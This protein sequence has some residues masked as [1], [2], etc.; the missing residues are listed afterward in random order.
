MSQSAPPVALRKPHSQ[1]VEKILHD[2]WARMNVK[3]EHFVLSVVGREGAGK[4]HTA[5]KLGALLD[6]QFSPNQILFGADELLKLLR[7]EEYRPGGVYVLDEAGV[8]FGSRTWQEKAQVKANQALQ[9]IRSHNI[10]LVFTLPRLSELDSQT[11]GR[12]HAFYEI[13][14]KVEGKF[15]RGK[16]KWVYP[17]RTGKTGE[18]YQQYPRTEDGKITSVSFE[19][20]GDALVEPY[21][22]RK[23]EFQRK[24]YDEALGELE[25]EDDSGG[26]SAAEI[27]DSIEESDS[28]SEY[29]REINGG[30]QVV[31]DKTKIQNDW[32]VG[33][34]K[35]KQV[36]SLLMERSD[37]EDIM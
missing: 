22:S 8:S 7:D 19:P 28:I 15:V 23:A 5:I 30:A 20:P 29:I 11:E 4:S 6:E 32:D 1:P 3:N 18:I 27:A 17:D 14:R 31:L 10:G 21:E 36:K 16:W 26:L 37:R 25:E 24:Q 33:R 9:L 13:T 12:L 35:S 2:C 34:P